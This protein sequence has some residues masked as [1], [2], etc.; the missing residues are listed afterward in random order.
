MR[1]LT[2]YVFAGAV[3]GFTFGI[4]ESIVERIFRNPEVP[5]WETAVSDEV[6]GA[7]LRA[8]SPIGGEG[9][10]EDNHL[11]VQGS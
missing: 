1:D 4:A 11:P 7:G 6:G 9:V 5:M 8:E 2:K 3:V 10:S